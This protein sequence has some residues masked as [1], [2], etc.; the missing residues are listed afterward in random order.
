MR[1]LIESRPVALE[2]GPE[3]A[4]VALEL[5]KVGIIELQATPGIALVAGEKPCA[6]P[7]VRYQAANGQSPVT[8]LLHRAIEIEGEDARRMLALLDGTRD[9]AALCSAMNCTRERL[10]TELRMLGRLGMLIA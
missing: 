1:L 9:R 7:L 3:Q 2:V 10:D 6:S 8:T 5:F 4:H